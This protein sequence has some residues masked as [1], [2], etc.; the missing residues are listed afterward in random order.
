MDAFFHGTDIRIVRAD[1]IIGGR[2]R[3]LRAST[4]KAFRPLG[5][6]P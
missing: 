6:A 3:L 5:T 4:V 1:A 2:Q